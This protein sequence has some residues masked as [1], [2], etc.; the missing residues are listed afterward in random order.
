MSFHLQRTTADIPMRS[1]IDAQV[2]KAMGSSRKTLMLLRKSIN[3][4]PFTIGIGSWK[5][6]GKNQS[7]LSGFE[8][9]LAGDLSPKSDYYR[10]KR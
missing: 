2:S 10:R 8:C 4:C 3:Q 1:G 5:A 7:W 9:W 6:E